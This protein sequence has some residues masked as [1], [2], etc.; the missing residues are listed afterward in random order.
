[1]SPVLR[2]TLLAR[3]GFWRH[4]LTAKVQEYIV[5]GI[6][7]STTGVA[8]RTTNLRQQVDAA[9]STAAFRSAGPRHP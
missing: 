2:A 4:V 8:A 6:D 7:P 9:L 3:R 5:D 1:M